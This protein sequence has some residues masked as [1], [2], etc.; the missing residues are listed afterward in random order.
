MVF[1]KGNQAA[2]EGNRSDER[3]GGAR[4]GSSDAASDGHSFCEEEGTGAAGSGVEGR[5]GWVQH[6]G[7][8][9][10]AQ[11]EP[12]HLPATCVEIEALPKGIVKPNDQ[13]RRNPRTRTTTVF[14]CRLDLIFG[15]SFGFVIP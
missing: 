11:S 3:E 13:V 2:P 10:L 4:T 7:L 6:A 1:S 15:G 9:H 8:A 14:T 12:Q 5:V